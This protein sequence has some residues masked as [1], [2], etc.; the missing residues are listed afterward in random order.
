MIPI[1]RGKETENQW[2]LSIIFQTVLKLFPFSFLP[3]KEAYQSFP[4]IFA[5]FAFISLSFHKS[6]TDQTH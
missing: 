3:S 6:Q 4:E 2:K 5:P 1:L